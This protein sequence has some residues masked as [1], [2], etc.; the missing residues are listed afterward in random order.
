MRLGKLCPAGGVGAE[1]LGHCCGCLELEVRRPGSL[2]SPLC[3]GIT[4][5]PWPRRRTLHF[6]LDGHG[7]DRTQDSTGELSNKPGCYLKE[8]AVAHNGHKGSVESEWSCVEP[9]PECSNQ[10]LASIKISGPKVVIT[11]KPE[12]VITR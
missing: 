2:T 4:F 12:T 1:A 7:E 3:Q 11:H 8:R 9:G 5:L 6:I 10:P